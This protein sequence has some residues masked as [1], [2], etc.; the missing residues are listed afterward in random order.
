MGI[1]SHNTATRAYSSAER[2]HVE[3]FFGT[4]EIDVLNLL[5]GYTGG[6]PGEL[7]GY[8]AMANGVMSVEQ[9]HEIITRYFIDEYPSIRHQGVTIGGRRPAEVYKAINETRGQIPPIDPHL[10]RINLGW[11]ENV[12][13]SDEGVRV[14][15]GIWFNSDKLQE[16]REEHRVTGKAKVFIDPDDMKSATVVMPNVKTPI[17]VNL[18]IT[19]FAD[20]TLPEILRLMAEQRREDPVTTEFHDDQVMRTRL[21]RYERIKAINV[22]HNLPRSY[23]TVEE[24]KE[25]A[26][27]VFAGARVIP[28][29]PIEGTTRPG[30]ITDLGTAEGVYTIGGAD[31]QIHS[32]VV[33]ADGLEISSSEIE[34]PDGL[35]S[36][37]TPTSTSGPAGKAKK[38]RRSNK[39]ATADQPLSRPK[40]PKVL[41]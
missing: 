11:E 34:G 28:S 16:Q 18:Q 38:K 36:Q 24:C 6:R 40:N 30:Q 8:D 22:E 7:P 41:K 25:K 14:C 17:E 2:P 29:K 21:H 9:L 1:G 10:R 20:M 23:S 31:A 37:E 5:P 15:H 26:K 33:N 4:L 19:A 27:A 39:P 13:S 32:E 35:D 12:T 3:R